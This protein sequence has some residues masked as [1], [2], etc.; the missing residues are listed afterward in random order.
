M[1]FVL[2]SLVHVAPRIGVRSFRSSLSVI[3]GFTLLRA[4]MQE[5][6]AADSGA[7]KQMRRR[8]GLKMGP[9]GLNEDMFVKAMGF[10]G[11]HTADASALF[12]KW[13]KDQ[14]NGIDF[15]EFTICLCATA[16]HAGQRSE[17]TKLYFRH[18]AVYP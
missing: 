17:A 9:D 4:I 13:D 16:R 1:A 2:R 7:A 3:G 14:S 11:V 10:M 8:L 12:A 6:G 18:V 15:D 5:G